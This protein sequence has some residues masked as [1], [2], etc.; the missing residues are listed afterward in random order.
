MGLCL[1][2][3]RKV[4]DHCE[5]K[6]ILMATTLEHLE[7]RVLWS[8]LLSG[9]VCGRWGADLAAIRLMELHAGDK[10]LAGEIREEILRNAPG[11]QKRGGTEREPFGLKPYELKQHPCPT[12]ALQFGLALYH[13]LS[14]GAPIQLEPCCYGPPTA[15]QLADFCRSAHTLPAS[16]TT[17]SLHYGYI[18][19]ASPLPFVSPCSSW[20]VATASVLMP[21]QRKHHPQ[22]RSGL[23]FKQFCNC[24][25]SHCPQQ[26]NSQWR[27]K[28]PFRFNGPVER[29]NL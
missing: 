21:K 28:T 1:T 22:L 5:M 24:S 8:V 16:A 18:Q 13:L 11:L 10:A 17:C 6:L 23:L 7:H 25:R 19:R 12:L 3:P 4:S 27:R 2:P 20:C 9:S 26:P 29:T 14:L 15:L